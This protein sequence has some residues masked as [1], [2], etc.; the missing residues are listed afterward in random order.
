MALPEHSEIQIVLKEENMALPEIPDIFIV[1]KE[2][3]CEYCG[4]T[5][6]QDS[7]KCKHCGAPVKR[8]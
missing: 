2:K 5:V 7:D 1:P 3:T 6:S 8:S 4:S